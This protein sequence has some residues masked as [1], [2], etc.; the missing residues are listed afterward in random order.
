M[1][2]VDQWAGGFGCLVLDVVELLIGRL[3]RR[4]VPHERVRVVLIT[5]YLG[6]GSIILAAPMIAKVRALYPAARIVFLTFRENREL[7]EMLGHFDEVMTIDTKRLWRLVVDTLAAVWRLWRA[8]VDVVCDLEFFARFSAVVAYLSGARTRAGYWSRI[9]WRGNLL[10]HPVYFNATKHITRVFLA[11]AEILGAAIDEREPPRLPRLPRNEEA[12]RAYGALVARAGFDAGGPM[13]LVNPNASEL[14][15]ERRWMADRFAS[16]VSTLLSENSR[17]RCVFIG[18]SSEAAY[19]ESV[20]EQ[21]RPR[22]RV[23]SLAG[24]LGLAELAEALRGAALFLTND[25]GP[26]HL[27]TLVDTPC[28]AIFGPETPGLYGPLGVRQKVHYAG[29]Y[30]SPCLNV[31]NSKTAACNG[32]NV[33]VQAIGLTPVIETC[34]ALLSSHSEHR[35]GQTAAVAAWR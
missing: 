8:R 21:C 5:K 2:R 19:T 25:S 23:V 35:A 10:T 11:Q 29:V 9:A 3:R 27:A 22:D 14:C 4:T 12:A 32:R 16:A 20:V 13:L 24:R 1:K 18:A 33:C 15:L 26:L 31:Y 17:L 28:V 34:R 7:A 30:C 6:M